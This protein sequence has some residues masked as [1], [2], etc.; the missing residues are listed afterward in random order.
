MGYSMT[1]SWGD[2]GWALVG[3]T[4]GMVVLALRARYVR[5]RFAAGEWT[6]FDALVRGGGPY[7]RRFT[8]VHV[9]VSDGTP[10]LTGLR[11]FRHS[12]GVLH[13]DHQRPPRLTELIGRKVVLV[14]TD[15]HGV[16]FELA[17]RPPDAPLLRDAFTR[18]PVDRD[19]APG[20]VDLDARRLAD[21][22]R[23][24]QP[25]G[26]GERAAWALATLLPLGVAWL[27]NDGESPATS[28]RSQLALAVAVVFLAV[29]LVVGAR[30]R[31]RSRR[32]RPVRGAPEPAFREAPP[33][34]TP[35][36]RGPAGP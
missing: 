26:P 15:A 35:Y 5:R 8:R 30:R 29:A 21:P 12:P 33:L 34:P 4:L 19:L 10:H 23:P 1:Y 11:G 18:G 25:P 13:V 20:L 22:A 32:P 9:V 24:L 7:P 16:P 31:A 14:G 36:S 2:I 17:V 6:Q 27:W 3:L 28:T